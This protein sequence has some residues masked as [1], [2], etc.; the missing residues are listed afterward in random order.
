MQSVLISYV[1]QTAVRPHSAFAGITALPAGEAAELQLTS[2]MGL[3]CPPLLTTSSTPPTFGT[4]LVFWAKFIGP[5]TGM[6]SK[7]E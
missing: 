3:T 7:G 5:G 2:R 4:A 1:G 6:G